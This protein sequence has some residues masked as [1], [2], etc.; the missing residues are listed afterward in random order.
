MRFFLKMFP[1]FH[2]SL[3]GVNLS[4]YLGRLPK[5]GSM[6]NGDIY[7]HRIL[8]RPTK[9]NDGSAW[10]TPVKSDADSGAIIGKNDH[11][12]TTS[13]GMPRKVNQNGKDGSVGLGRLV[14]LW[15]TPRT[16]VLIGGSGSKQ[17]MQG[18]VNMGMDQS[19]AEMMSGLKLW[20]TPQARDW[21]GETGANR[22]SENLPDTMKRLETID[23]LVQVITEAVQ[24]SRK[25]FLNPEFVELL[26]GF[27]VGWT[28]L[29]FPPVPDSSNT[30]MSRHVQ[31]LARKRQ[32]RGLRRSV[33]LSCL[34]LRTR[35]SR[36]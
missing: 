15:P 12:Y 30:P 11:Y 22:H 4:T 34:K 7:E 35:Y 19:E 10:P 3:M 28:S 9:G 20:P 2:H 5:W 26:M 13:T 6:R 25:K 33:T 24:P 17:M 14:K 23:D 36:R 18:A 31:R 27:P 16:F 29:D 1:A 21:K 8:E 32:T